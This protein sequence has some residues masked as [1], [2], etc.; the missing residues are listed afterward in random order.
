MGFQQSSHASHTGG[1]G[2]QQFVRIGYAWPSNQ[3]PPCQVP[4]PRRVALVTGQAVVKKK[5]NSIPHSTSKEATLCR[6][7]RYFEA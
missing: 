3:S 4:R 1:S 5:P 6:Y 2:L 7:F